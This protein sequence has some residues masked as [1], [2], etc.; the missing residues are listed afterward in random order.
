MSAS[1]WAANKD[2]PEASKPVISTI[3]PTGNPP[4]GLFE[5]AKSNIVEP[6][7]IHSFT[8]DGESESPS[9]K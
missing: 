7:E 5:I 2:L 8:S 1:A 4:F 3:L 9:K 6:V